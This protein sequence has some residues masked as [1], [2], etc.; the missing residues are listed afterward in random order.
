MPRMYKRSEE[1]K[2]RRLERDRERH[3]LWTASGGRAAHNRLKKAAE[4]AA[5]SEYRAVLRRMATM[6]WAP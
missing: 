3:R 6:R 2:L 1:A 5:L 4:A